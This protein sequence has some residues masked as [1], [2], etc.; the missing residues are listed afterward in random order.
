[1]CGKQIESGPGSGCQ[2]GLYCFGTICAGGPQTIGCENLGGGTCFT[3]AVGLVEHNGLVLDA[4]EEAR[5]IFR[6]H[7]SG[8]AEVMTSPSFK[9][10]S[11]VLQFNGWLPT[12][13]AFVALEYLKC[14][15]IEWKYLEPGAVE[16]TAKTIAR[17]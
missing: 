4:P 16:V 5:S 11:M 7:K 10:G 3:C 12:P 15:S 8:H 2:W 13:A 17:A 1:M 6:L 14:E 9:P